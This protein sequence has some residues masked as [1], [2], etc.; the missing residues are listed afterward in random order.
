MPP[1]VQMQSARVHPVP[2]AREHCIKEWVAA[3]HLA[4]P[5]EPE[6]AETG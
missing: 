1:I 5:V 4:A 2:Q 3:G 6:G